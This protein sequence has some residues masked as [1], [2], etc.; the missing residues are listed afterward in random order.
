MTDVPGVPDLVAL[1]YR[2][3]W[4]RLSLSASVH[5]LVDDSARFRMVQAGAV[6]LL[7]WVKPP[8]PS[9]P[10]ELGVREF[11]ATLRV[12]PGG[13]FR[14]DVLAA[15]SRDGLAAE[16]G[17]GSPH[18]RAAPAGWLYSPIC[19]RSWARRSKIGVSLKR[20]RSTP[21]PPAANVKLDQEGTATRSPCPRS[22][23]S[24]SMIAVPAPWKTWKTEE[25]TSRLVIVAAPGRS[26]WNS[27]RIVGIT[28][29][30]VAGLVNRIAAWPFS[31]TPG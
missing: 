22:C 24:P 26:R 8:V 18:R 11:R 13:R 19:T 1:F 30:P 28:S 27:A 17:S 9:P 20:N 10:P 15:D 14:V 25:P 3:D 29:P 16:D 2:A 7:P 6:S 12:A 5:G 4:T 23:S 31:T 21:A